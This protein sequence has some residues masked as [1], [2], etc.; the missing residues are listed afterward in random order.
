MSESLGDMFVRF[1]G[2]TRQ[3]DNSMR[4]IQNQL[5]NIQ[6]QSNRG[7]GFGNIFAGMTL[8]GLAVNAVTSAF[9]MLTSAIKSAVTAGIE[10]NSTMQQNQT[11]FGTMLG[12]AKEAK[13]LMSS[14]QDFASK[15][16]LETEDLTKGTRILLGYG[17]AAENVMPMLKMIGDVAQGDKTR[18]NGL[19]LAFGQVMANGRLMG[20]EVLQMVSNGFNPLQAIS[21]KTGKSMAQLKQEM[22]Q[23]K[24]SAK[25]VAE[26]FQFA[27]S[28][29]GRFYGAME[30]QSK[31]FAGQL[32]T[33]KDNISITLG[34]T[35]KPAFETITNQVLPAF[36]SELNKPNSATKQLLSSLGTMANLMAS[37][38][39]PVLNA[40]SWTGSKVGEVMTAIKDSVYNLAITAKEALKGL[41]NLFIGLGNS[42]VWAYNK[43]TG[44]KAGMMDYMEIED[45]TKKFK[46]KPLT[47]SQQKEKDMLDE[48]KA[49]TKM[50]LDKYKKANASLSKFDPY[51]EIDYSKIINSTST[52]T[53]SGKSVADKL[54]EE[55]E[56]IVEQMRGMLNDIKSKAES[57]RDAF[58]IFS[59]PK[60]EKLSWKDL[61]YRMQK[62]LQMMNQWKTAMQ[63]IGQKMGYES[64]IYR[65]T[66]AQGPQA[67]GQ[68]MALAS[69][70]NNELLKFGEM[71][72][73][74]QA[75]G[76]DFAGQQQSWQMKANNINNNVTFN[77]TEA[78]DSDKIVQEITK[79]FKLVGVM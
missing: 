16:P 23:G 9:N 44:A 8:G 2:D 30:A 73:A 25:M 3:F 22:E 47:K 79:K 41:S 39:V 49:M 26:A 27:T 74:K 43:I 13:E 58:D 48:R 63:T 17:V 7:S 28:E 56:K 60:M 10:Y 4:H 18:M 20:Q 11:A 31:T 21:E 55:R 61:R 69:M 72:N 36:Q 33:L 70:P 53:K 71:Y 42:V 14:I 45:V 66:L 5:N 51:K 1:G 65:A 54:K 6:Q 67:V 68:A 78:S 64:P 24:I 32:S 50:K 19:A 38:I 40:L 34:E 62:Q 77:I 15:T 75:I 12:S 52:S 76:V 37:S 46:G 57:I 35:M 59:S 29:G